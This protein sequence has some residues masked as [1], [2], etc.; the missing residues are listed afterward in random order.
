ME[1]KAVKK[2][3]IVSPQL[4][5]IGGIETVLLKVLHSRLVKDFQFSLLILG[6]C[7][8][9]QERFEN[10]TDVDI[11]ITDHPQN[12]LRAL[13]L[14]IY[15]LRNK[16]DIVICLSREELMTAF[17]IRKI[18]NLKYKIVS[19]IHFSLKGNRTNFKKYADYHLSISSENTKMLEEKGILGKKIFTIYNPVSFADK[20][21]PNAE[22]KI[23]FVYVGRI[24]FQGQKNLKELIDGLATWKEEN[25][26]VSFYGTGPDVKK[27][28][29][30]IHKNYSKIESKFKWCGWQKK[31]WRKIE[32]A[33]ALILTSSFEGFPM[34][35]LEAISRGLPCISSDCMTG[36]KD[37][38][39]D[40]INGYLYKLNDL[41]DLHVKLDKLL[42]MKRTPFEIKKSINQF[43]DETY[44]NSLK[45]ILIKI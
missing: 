38:I 14:A 29:D 9:N 40:G 37:I 41:N 43:S 12:I 32:Q 34:V 8:A 10:L 3:L 45:K 2:I 15:L 42:L 33:S 18:F 4:G 19:W 6:G 25:W 31:P 35:L 24:I 21:I 5:G 16:E 30:Y 13:G 44:L 20:T 39:K 1:A 26:V 7:K 28:K 27:S 11:H 23:K 17:Y 22:G 36:P